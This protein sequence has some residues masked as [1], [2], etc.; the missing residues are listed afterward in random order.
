MSENMP[1]IS[2]PKKNVKPEK[3]MKQ[4]KKERNSDKVN[5]TKNQN[6]T[7]SKAKQI[8][9]K[10]SKTQNYKN[11]SKKGRSKQQKS[12]PCEKVKIAFLGGINEVGKNI[13][14][15]EYGDDMFIVDCGLAFPDQDMPGVDLVIPDFTYL[16]KN[17]EKIKGV[18]ITHGHEDHIGALA[19]LLKTVNVPVFGTRLTIGL[20]EGKLKEHKMLGNVILKTVEP[21]DE[22]TLGKFKV[23]FI[24]VN[25]SIP[26]AV[27]LAIKSPAGVI[28]QTGDFKIDCTPIDG[29]MI[30]IARFAQL[31]K[32]G[33]LALLSDSTNAERPGFTESEKKVGESFGLLFRKAGQR[34]IIVA[35]FASNIHRV[36]QIIDVAKSLGRKVALSG[37][38]LENVVTIGTELG[39]LKVPENILISIDEINK[40]T[41]EQIVLITTGSQGEPMSALT[42]MAFSD[43]RKVSITPNDYVII[44]ANP[45]PG[46][47]KMVGNVINEL[48]MLGAEVVYEKMYDVHVSG[49]ACQEELK[50][51]LGIVKP[52]YFIPVHGE[53]KHLQK[54]ALLAEHMGIN[55]KNILIVENGSVFELAQDH[56][57]RLENVQAGR[58]F[59]DGTG[60]GDVGSIVIRDRKHL[61]SDG[62]IIIVATIDSASGELLSGPDVVSRG[63]VYVRESEDLIEDAKRISYE[64]LMKCQYK[65]IRE[66]NT[67]KNRIRDDVSKLMYE[68]TKRSPM[69]LPII[70]EV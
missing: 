62:L 4:N 6:K 11:K 5:Q 57:K 18:V 64:S 50:M 13:T 42:R 58:V 41:P 34:R 47:E 8:Q 25:H 16:E 27:A 36:Q 1:V 19:Y 32:E 14:L 7:T 17:V 51:M 10:Q 15:Y 56:V 69:I 30:D 66:W 63:F 37:R 3:K 21:G 12:K 59:V 22:I 45:I 68:K 29:G 24:H 38:S 33:V 28:V 54:H 60:V 70:M 20:I 43:H 48:M 9:N 55:R 52:Q 67:I 35:T 61:S 40:Y 31:G 44:S 53:H 2:K 65:N 46:N 23:G 49:H 39:Y 26:D